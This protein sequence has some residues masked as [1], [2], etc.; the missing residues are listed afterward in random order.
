MSDLIAFLFSQACFFERSDIGRGHAVFESKGCASCH[1]QPR[2]ETNAPDLTQ[3]FE[4]Y[5]PITLIASVWRHG[6]NM[7]QTMRRNRITWP[8]FHRSDMADLIAYLNSRLIV[9]VAP[10]QN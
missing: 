8:Q 10:K 7:F 4:V 2:K 3:A 9:R 6:P 5:S 1:E